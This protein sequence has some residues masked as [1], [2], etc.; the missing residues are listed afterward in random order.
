VICLVVIL[1]GKLVG[2]YC[3]ILKELFFALLDVALTVHGEIVG[4]R[5]L[6][7]FPPFRVEE[8]ARF[9]LCVSDQERR[10]R[11]T[12]QA[13]R[14][15]IKLCIDSFL[16]VPFERGVNLQLDLLQFLFAFLGLKVLIPMILPRTLE[17][18]ERSLS[19]AS[20]SMLMFLSV[21]VCI[22]AGLR[23]GARLF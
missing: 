12:A 9:L 8:K 3:Y 19:V 21:M 1:R 13:G 4:N 16:V 6:I 23:V 15:Q 14:D 17:S 7:I 20:L 11:A 2:P 10:S 5:H 18:S 22:I